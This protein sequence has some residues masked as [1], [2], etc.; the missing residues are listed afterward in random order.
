MA[1]NNHEKRITQLE[2]QVDALQKK[3]GGIG[4]EKPW[5]ERIAGSFEND[6]IYAKAMKLGRKYRESLRPKSNP[7]SG[8]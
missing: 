2:Q 6:P 1:S 3:I 4:D 7:A 8:E 5:W